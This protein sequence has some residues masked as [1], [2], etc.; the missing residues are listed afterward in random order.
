MSNLEEFAMLPLEKMRPDIAELIRTKHLKSNQRQPKT[1]LEIFISC[2][3]V[4]T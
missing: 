1:L 3:R 4:V 2:Y